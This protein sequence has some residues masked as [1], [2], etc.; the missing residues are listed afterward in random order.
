MWVIFSYLPVGSVNLVDHISQQD[1]FFHCAVEFLIFGVLADLQVVSFERLVHAEREKGKIDAGRSFN[2]LFIKQWVTNYYSFMPIPWNK[3]LVDVKLPARV[4]SL[5]ILEELT[6]LQLLL[7]NCF[8]LL[9]ELA[10]VLLALNIHTEQKKF[11]WGSLLL[12]IPSFELPFQHCIFRLLTFCGSYLSLL[13]SH[14]VCML[15]R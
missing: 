15:D 14:S 2:Q 4:E 7:I 11:S 13:I 8:L 6:R 9:C 10:P 3:E 12:G 1:L 5:F